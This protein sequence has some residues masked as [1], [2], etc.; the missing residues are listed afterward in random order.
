MSIRILLPL[1]LI[2]FSFGWSH[3]QNLDGG[4]VFGFNASQ[5]DGD[6]DGGFRQVGPVL[7][8]Y[9][10]YP[11]SSRMDLQA[12][13]IFEQLGS[14]SKGRFFAIRTSHI[15]LP[16]LL[17]YPL[18]ID[19]GEEKRQLAFQAGPVIGTLLG[20]KDGVSGTDFSTVY[21]NFDLRV[22]AGAGYQFKNRWNVFLRYGYSIISFLKGGNTPTY[23]RPGA[24]GLYHKYVQF[25]LQYDL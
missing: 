1:W 4:I 22:L 13:L 2:C 12:E 24:P 17:T 19:L 16:L 20:A 14:V 21:R 6:A 5:V 11:I 18:E 8:G 15:S 7:G 25:S 23:L 3:G 10:S 9:V